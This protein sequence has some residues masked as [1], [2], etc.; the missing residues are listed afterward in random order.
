MGMMIE[1]RTFWDLVDRRAAA[2]PGALMGLDESLRTMSFRQYRDAA[3]S[4]AAGLHAM[5]VTA[6]TVV[7]WILPTRFDALILMAALA[8]LGAVQVPILP[9]YRHRE[10]GFCLRETGARHVIVPEV[11]KE[12]SHADMVCELATDLGGLTIVEFGDELPA[13]D[14][15][16]LPPPPVDADEVRWIFYTSGTTGNPKGARHTDRGVLE[17]SVGMARAMDLGPDDRIA[18]VFPVTHLGGA[19]SLTAALYSGAG[20]LIVDAFFAPGVLDF[21]AAHGVTHAG[22]GTVFHQAY[23]A[24]QRA[25]GDGPIFPEIRVF[26]GGGAPKPPQ[27]HYDL[28]REIGGAGILSVYG[29]TEC[30][31]ISLGRIDDPDE[32]LAYTEGRFNTPGTE[33]RVVDPDTG[34]ELPAGREGELL[35]RAPQLCKGYVDESLNRDAFTED[36]FFRTGDL[37]RID[38]GGNLIIAGRQKDVIIRKGENI[39][40]LEIEQLLMRHPK[41]A[42]VA[43]IGLPEEERGE[44]CCAVVVAAGDQPITLAELRAYLEGEKLM[45]QKIPE[46]LELVAALPKNP[47]GKV[48]KKDLKGQFR[49]R[50]PQRA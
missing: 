2:T 27:L 40:P 9:I 20:H 24:A 19:N 36:G 29:M 47:T 38:D 50:V 41:V 18:L 21:L 10:V 46:Q 48:L 34:A 14:V 39:A 15:G 11:Y 43:V 5:G 33:Y 1:A 28:K 44:L 17:S 45:R 32:K 26:Q 7:S 3:E 25:R 35:L 8:R 31:I 13:G 30:P 22:A 23:L 49:A 6:G 42:D 4:L 16:A 12:F 37:V